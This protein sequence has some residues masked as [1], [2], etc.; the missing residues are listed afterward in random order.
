M[1]EQPKLEVTQ[2]PSGSFFCIEKGATGSPPVG[3]GMSVLE[4]VGLW[5]INSSTVH[6]QCNPPAVLNEYAVATPYSELK[7]YAPSK[8]D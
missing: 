1:K 6:I 2:K 5:A 3:R 8:R 4:A 7:F